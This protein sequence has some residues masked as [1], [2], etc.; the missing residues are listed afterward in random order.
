M[1]KRTRPVAR[2]LAL[3]LVSAP[4]LALAPA[5]CSKPPP[6]AEAPPPRVSV[7]QAAARELIDSDDFNGWLDSS[8]TV[9]VRA[10]VR[11]HIQKVH[12]TDG[13]MVKKG[14]LLFELDPRPFQQE[15]DRS[16]EQVTIYDAQLKYAL[17]EEKRMH[18]MQKEGV[19][20]GIEIESAEAKAR[21]LEA[22]V[23]AQKKE[24]ERDKLEL[25]Y[26][27]I[28]APIDGR[29]SRAMM[30]EGN[31][32]N[33]GGSDPVLT[34]IVS[35]DPIYVYFNVD[36]R[37]LQRYQRMNKKNDA[38]PSNLKE[39][40]VEITFGLDADQGYP[41]KATLDFADNR[42]DPTT[43]TVQVRGIAKGERA[44][45]PGSRV[46]VR[47]PVSESRQAVLVPD[48]AILSDQDKKY[49]LVVDE[50]N[51][52]H[53]RDVQLGKLLDDG[54]RVVLPAQGAEQALA[55]SERFIVEG[56]QAARLN[57]P[58]EP[59]TPT[60]QPTKVAAASASP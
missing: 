20:S 30:T 33:A 39:T 9:E 48:T 24:V 3:T 19:A 47:V 1:R 15:I 6:R 44:F 46:R 35:M 28:D 32:V 25:E 51:V 27:R 16:I 11:G 60:T 29:V 36:E 17:V 54:M 59:I 26:S 52:V 18:Q 38:G 23:E 7:Q 2:F 12:F 53:R 4:A 57:Y 49:L 5:G 40:K 41:H 31:L 22:Q 58:V 37:T 14:D 10:R 55:A 43:G 21:S 56:L 42:V 8:A 45:T 50:K 34:T 13:Q